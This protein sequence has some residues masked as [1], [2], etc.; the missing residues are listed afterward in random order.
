VKTSLGRSA[1]GVDWE[2]PSAVLKAIAEELGTSGLPLSRELAEM[3]DVNRD[4]DEQGEWIS[5][6]PASAVV[7]LLGVPMTGAETASTLLLATIAAR[8]RDA[9]LDDESLLRVMAL[10]TKVVARFES[11]VAER[12][13]VDAR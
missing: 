7:E 3:I 2:T 9:H 4:L 1:G 13:A 10:A 12:P 11:Y 8:A 5:L 6:L